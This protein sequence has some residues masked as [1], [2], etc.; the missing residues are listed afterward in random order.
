VDTR[1]RLSK[2]SDGGPSENEAGTKSP[3]KL[4]FKLALLVD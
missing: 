3:V 2:G 1:M 4:S